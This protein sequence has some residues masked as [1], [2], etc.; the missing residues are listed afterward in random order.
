MKTKILRIVVV[1]ILMI[2]TAYAII[3][4]NTNALIQEVENVMYGNVDKSVTQDS[5]LKVYNRKG[6][7]NTTHTEVEL[8]RLFVIH[9]FFDGYMW[10]K[11]S[12]EDFD[13]Q[14][15]R[16][17][18]SWNIVSKWKIHKENGKWK[19]VEIIEKP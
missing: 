1:V 9:N 17:Y 4:N 7:F 6:E 8:T 13:E 2:L 14:D 5:P 10:V 15:R 19:I 12:Y 18:G 3:F 16:T 11:Y